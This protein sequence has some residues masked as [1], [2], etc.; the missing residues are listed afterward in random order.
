VNSKQ[1]KTLRA[2]FAEPVSGKIEWAAIE[3]LLKSIGCEVVEGSGS[4]V[5]FR[6]G[7]LI[8]SFHRPHPEKEAKRYQVRDAREFLTKIG[9]TP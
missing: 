4:A 5:K 2:I 8:A 1:R 6:Q 9:I 3:S 7:K